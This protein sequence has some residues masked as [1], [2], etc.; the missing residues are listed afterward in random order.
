MIIVTGEGRKCAKEAIFQVLNQYPQAGKNVLLSESDLK[1]PQDIEGLKFLVNKSSLFILVVSHIGDISPDPVRNIP[2]GKDI[3]N[4][5]DWV[6]YPAGVSNGADKDF[7]AGEREKTEEIRKLAKMIPVQ[8]WLILNFDD[9]TVR[10]IADVTNLKTL[11]FGFQQGADFQASDI[12][13]N[14]RD[15]SSAREAGEPV[16]GT[17]FKINYKGNIVPVWMEGVFGK[18]QIYSALTAV[19]IGTILDLNLIEIS[20]ALKN[21]HFG[22]RDR[23]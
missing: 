21:Y 12:K 14:G 13:L 3:N 2:L 23:R 1:D 17:N 9:E 5:C 18:E 11:T 6:S 10:E 15:A 8:N 22:K 20:Q 4:S 16:L 19:C 7:F